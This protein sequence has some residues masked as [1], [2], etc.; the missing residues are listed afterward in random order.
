MDMGDP[1]GFAKDYIYPYSL[2][3]NF[4]TASEI[5]FSWIIYAKAHLFNKKYSAPAAACLL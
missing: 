5:H 1:G 2:H 3:H 4:L